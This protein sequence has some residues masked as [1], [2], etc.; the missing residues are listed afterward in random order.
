MPPVAGVLRSAF[1][2]LFGLA[3]NLETRRSVLHRIDDRL[4][5]TR[6]V[7]ED[8]CFAKHDVLDRMLSCAE[9]LD[10]RGDSHFDAGDTRQQHHSADTVI[11]NECW[12]PG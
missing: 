12:R 10:S 5:H 4:H 9:Q 6:A 11:I 7:R 2:A 8:H 3:L 1:I